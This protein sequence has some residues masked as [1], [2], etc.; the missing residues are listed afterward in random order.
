[1]L[2]SNFLWTPLDPPSI[3]Y[4][5]NRIF[6]EDPFLENK[7]E[8]QVKIY[9]VTNKL[10]NHHHVLCMYLLICFLELYLSQ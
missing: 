7:L 5:S 4:P 6:Q 9:L 8:S 3:T 1:M 10:I 2:L